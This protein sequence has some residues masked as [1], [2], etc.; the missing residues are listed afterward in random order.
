[1]KTK[2]NLM[3]LLLLMF[4]CCACLIMCREN[5]QVKPSRQQAKNGE[6]L[7]KQSMALQG[8]SG[9][10]KIPRDSLETHGSV[11]TRG[12]IETHGSLETQEIDYSS[13]LRSLDELAELER[14]GTWFQGLAL[15]ESGLRENA[16]DFAGAIAAAFKELAMAYGMGLIQK[17]EIEQGL[18]NVITVKN[19]ETVSANIVRVTANAII[20]FLNEQW[21]DAADNFESVFSKNPYHFVNDEPDSFSRWMMLVCTL[22]KNKSSLEAEDRKA[23][24]AYRSI[25]ARYVQFPEYWYRGARAFSGVIAAEFAENCI[26]TAP[27]GP[28]AEECRRILAAYTGLKSDEGLSIKTKKEIEAVISQSVSSGNPNTLDSLLPLIS[29]PDN[30]YTVYA[31]GALRAL[32]SV[33]K[34]REY[35][36]LQAKQVNGA[37][38][39][40]LRRLAERLAYICRG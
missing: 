3:S 26:N 1:M 4:V 31:V 2:L 14:A 7:Y 24:L 17:N 22:E 37:K 16:G 9:A 35:F 40:S 28:Y 13:L 19:E 20:S 10:E 34:Y 15:T 12:S 6:A 21:V 30:P 29:L 38:D 18:L 8:S 33:P 27:Q 39:I 11:E 5:D 23:G 32:T 25:R 36:N